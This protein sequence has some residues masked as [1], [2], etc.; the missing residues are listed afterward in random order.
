MLEK[1]PNNTEKNPQKQTHTLFFNLLFLTAA[2]LTW[3]QLVFALALLL[4]PSHLSIFTPVQMHGKSKTT[5]I[6]IGER[7]LQ[8]MGVVLTLSAF[9]HVASRQS[10]HCQQPCTVSLVAERWHSC[11][12]STQGPTCTTWHIPT[13]LQHALQTN[14]PWEHAWGCLYRPPDWSGRSQSLTA[15]RDCS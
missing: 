2:G 4:L 9:I 7:R 14:P 5:S 10:L 8:S 13:G 12:G 1:K 11:A 3:K 6:L 15:L